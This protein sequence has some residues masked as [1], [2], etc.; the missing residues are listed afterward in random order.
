MHVLDVALQVAD[1]CLPS[2]IALFEPSVEE[3]KCLN[4]DA[5]RWHQNLYYPITVI[6]TITNDD[7]HFTKRRM[8][9]QI[10]QG[11]RKSSCLL[12]HTLKDALGRF[13]ESVSSPCAT[14]CRSFSKRSA[15]R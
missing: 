9:V 13:D 3:Q 2:F 4:H 5:V 1:M 6:E 12:R 10:G 11:W 7:T 15:G 8:L 14:K